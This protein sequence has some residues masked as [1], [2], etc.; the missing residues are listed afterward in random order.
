MENM[1]KNS[2]HH[3]VQM[4]AIYR[5]Q[6]HFYDLT[7]KYYLLGRDQ[8]IADMKP[9]EN[10]HI[11]EIGCGT[12]R[13]I[14]AAAKH[15]PDTQFYGLDI[16]EAMLEM[17]RKNIEKAGVAD[18]VMLKKADASD[19][20]ASEI[21]G[22]DNFNRIFCSYTLS[23]I[24]DWQCAIDQ[25]VKACAAEGL[26]HIVDFGNQADLPEVFAK[27][28]R[29]WLTKFHVSP[30]DDM[31]EFLQQLSAMA[32]L[33]IIHKQHYRGYAQYAVIHKK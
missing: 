9:P 16:S 28:L 22:R 11:L 32:D 1:V 18:R 2:A 25:A 14:I 26:V 27:L 3:G 5:T 21:F 4:D 12:G 31:P 30:R 24:S 19:F 7:R 13:N 23:M 20:S 17:A 6:R 10:A 29:A 8:L 33:N 15:Y